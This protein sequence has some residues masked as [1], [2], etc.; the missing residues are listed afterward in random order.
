[1]G[2]FVDKDKIATSIQVVAQPGPVFVKLRDKETIFA[3]D[4]VAAFDIKNNLVILQLS[5]EGKPL[6]ISDSD[7]VQ[8]SDSVSVIGYSD[9][10]YKATPGIIKNILKSNKWFWTKVATSKEIS[11]APVLND[12]G[13]V[14]GATVG[15]GDGSHSYVIP[16]NALKA[17]LTKSAPLESLTEWKKREHIRAEVHQSQGE[18]KYAAKKYKK[19]IVDFDRVIELNPE[20]V[21][22]H[23]KRGNSK[24]KL[25]DYVSA[26]KDYTHAIKLNPKHARAYNN[27]GNTKFKLENYVDAIDDLTHA[28]KLNPENAISY[29][30]RG[31]VKCK[32]GI[33]NRDKV[34]QRWQYGYTTKVLLTLV[35]LFN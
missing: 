31:I 32:L 16:S 8:R 10:K 22:A 6:S 35:N 33:S 29:K 15:Y 4:G 27:R 24:F 9:E 3:V 23:Y 1:M 5:G 26:I 28:I 21:R 17:L 12:N 34:M 7:V 25:E 13:Q 11:G 20:H 18:Q 19:A 2:F 30:N 14:I